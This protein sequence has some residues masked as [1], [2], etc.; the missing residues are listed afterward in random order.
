MITLRQGVQEYLSVR[1]A[2]G[3]KQHDAGKG[4]L[5]F[6]TFMEQRRAAYITPA[7]ALAWAQ[8]PRYVQ[9]AQWAQR[10]T[11]VRVF[12]RHRRATDP[13]TQIPPP[14][15]LPFQPKRAGPYLIHIMRSRS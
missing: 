3:F 10:L 13:R 2:L 5:D 4:L 6:V 11:Y 7:L 8:Q 9:P 15:L 12:A 14:G 1:R